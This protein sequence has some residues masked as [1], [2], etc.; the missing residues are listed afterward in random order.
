M[1]YDKLTDHQAKYFAHLLT[2]KIPS[3]DKEKLISTILD[4]QVEPKPHQID[5]ALFAFRSPFANGAILADEVGLGK[6]IEAGLVIAQ[7]WAEGKKRILIICP[8]SLRQQ[9][10]QELQDKFFLSS[11]ILEGKNYNTLTKENP[12]QSPFIQSEI[13][14]CS[15]Q[16]ASNKESDISLISWDLV[17]IDEAHRLRNVYKPSNKTSNILKKALQRAPK[18]LLTA[19]PLQNSLLELYGLV[20]FID[21]HAFGDQKSFKDQF[22]N[23]G[24]N[25]TLSDLRKRLSRFTFRTLR[26]QVME[27]INYTNRVPHTQSYQP[28]EKEQELYNLVSEYL[29]R[30]I[31]YALPA[32]QR[33]LT[34][35]VMR[36]LLASSSYAIS[37]TLNTLAKRL[38]EEIAGGKFNEPNSLTGFFSDFELIDELE[39]E[40][41]VD[42]VSEIS[43]SQAINIKLAKQEVSDLRNY[44]RIAESIKH[45]N[46]ADALQHGLEACFEQLQRLGAQKKAIIFTE[47]TRTQKYLFDFLNDNGSKD[48]I[49]LFNGSNTD[50]ASTDIYH[51]WLKENSNTDRVTGTTTADRKAAIVDDF[52][53]HAEIMIATEAA[54]E[55]INLQFCSLVVNYDL[56]WNPQ[57]VE[58]RIGR[59]HRYGQKHDVVVLNFLNESNAADKRVFELLSEKFKLFEGVFGVSDEVLGAIESGVDIEKRIATIYQT[60]RTPDEI[61]AEFDQLQHDLESEIDSNM[62]STKQKLLEN[63]DKDVHEKLRISMDQSQEYL[64]KH[65]KWLW[66]VTKHQ[67]NNRAEFDENN[68]SFKLLDTVFDNRKGEHYQMKPVTD[69]H[70]YRA[71]S[72]LAQQLLLN[73][74][75][76]STPTSSCDIRYSLMTEKITALEPLL[77][78]SGYLAVT[79]LHIN[80]INEEEYVITSGITSDN[81][82]LSDEQ[83]SH[84]LDLRFSNI[85]QCD[86]LKNNDHILLDNI[87]NEQIKIKQAEIAERN[88]NYFDEELD[89]IESWAEDKKLSLE[90][91]IKELDKEIKTRRTE[92]RKIIKLDIKVAEQRAIKDL[93]K[94][95][96]SLRRELFDKQDEIDNEKDKLLD[97]VQSRLESESSIEPLFVLEWK[98]I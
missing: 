53:N 37:K 17:V 74:K 24:N 55:G 65:E 12:K 38:E 5:A 96:N 73:A 62:Q 66:N 3:N 52:R 2:R 21:E 95:R 78:L 47:S 79:I 34:T 51:K 26:K 28:S 49:V 19:T 64:N 39:E 6:T 7:K 30:D 56:P 70:L 98:L 89:K 67:L 11:I 54:A 86:N 23:R 46:K 8:S 59:C 69:A 83:C 40:S 22:I 27:Y 48:K 43:D 94:K 71:G 41:G 50:P 36:K 63:F 16:F 31:I 77:G 80:G 45:N 68:H 88:S 18:L 15:Y 44:A 60:C 93:E 92:A 82:R 81:K 33:Q 9:W 91:K 90:L 32:G 87:I 35:L 61:K 29:Q 4:A 57:R 76:K 13:V 14:M 97:T 58:Q 75:E 25:T 42:G 84:L 1:S 10:R 72:P 20:S 85:K